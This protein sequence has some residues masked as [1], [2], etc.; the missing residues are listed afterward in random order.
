MRGRLGAVLR[1]LLLLAFSG[2]CAAAHAQDAPPPDHAPPHEQPA[3][4]GA[5]PDEQPPDGATPPVE[6]PPDDA[7]PP[8]EPPPDD[9]SAPPA[10]PGPAPRVEQ[11]PNEE[12]GLTLSF[13]GRAGFVH[14]PDQWVAGP[15]LSVR[16]ILADFLQLDVMVLA[17]MATE[18]WTLR[19]SAHLSLVMSAGDFRFFP[20]VGPAGFIY[21]PRGAFADWCEKLQLDACGGS[22]FGMELGLG[23][24]WRALG[25]EAY[26]ST[27]ELPLLTVL[28]S[29]TF[30]L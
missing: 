8:V 5:V 22:A 28:G 2:F 27:G 4:A 13:G 26:L 17:G 14:Q 16:G 24:G 29:V 7:T 3:D 11:L 21:R 30:D 10:E 9:A 19:V 6:P 20:L 15:H 18:H 12:D 23:A 1:M 25:I